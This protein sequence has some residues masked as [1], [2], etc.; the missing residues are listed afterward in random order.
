MTLAKAGKSSSSKYGGILRSYA[1]RRT[2]S[3]FGRSKVGEPYF[4]PVHEPARVDLGLEPGHGH[5]HGDARLPE[6]R[7][8]LV[9]DAREVEVQV[10]ADRADALVLGGHD[11]NIAGLLP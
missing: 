7:V 11:D 6:E 1:K 8:L 9:R 3:V 2:S 5:A 4:A 10:V